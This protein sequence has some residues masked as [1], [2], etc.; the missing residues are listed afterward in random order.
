[1]RNIKLSIEYDGT[2]YQ[3]WQIQESPQ[4]TIQ[5]EIERALHIIFK[6]DISITGSGRTDSGV[7]A[8]GQVANFNTESTMPNEEIIRALN[9]NLPEDISILKAEEVDPDFNARYSAKEKTYKYT[10]LNRREKPAINRKTCLHFPHK[11]SMLKMQSACKFL[12]G[13]HDFKS[14]QAFDSSK[15]ERS[16][17]TIRTIKQINVVRKGDYITIFITADGFLYK[18]VRNIVGTLIDIGRKEIPPSEIKKILE[19]K[20]RELA[21][22][23][24]PAHGL[25]LVEVKY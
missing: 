7:H 4:K 3:G 19:G 2:N 16:Q 6:S 25:C 21:S 15:P 12:I 23:T 20:D 5:G 1:M 8:L 17:D 14:F 22:N 11:L 9:G 13:T 24:A 10:I 18:M